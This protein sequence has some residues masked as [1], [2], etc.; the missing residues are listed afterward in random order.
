MGGPLRNKVSLFEHSLST[1]QPR[2]ESTHDA[3]QWKIL[4]EVLSLKKTGNKTVKDLQRRIGRFLS[5]KRIIQ[6]LRPPR[7]EWT[8]IR[9]S[10][11][12]DQIVG[13]TLHFRQLS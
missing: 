8:T 12:G 3:Y 13:L 10:P 5:L 4:E 7:R 11:H 6:S 2:L 1:D 9:R